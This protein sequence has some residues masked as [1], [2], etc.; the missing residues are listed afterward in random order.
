MGKMKGEIGKL[1]EQTNQGPKRDRT[2]GIPE[3]KQT[4][5][6]TVDEEDGDDSRKKEADGF[7]RQN[8]QHM[9]SWNAGKRKA[10]KWHRSSQRQKPKEFLC[11]E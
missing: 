5:P 7:G 1:G 3:E 11:N 10:K 4:I 8:I 6:V 9:D 2:G